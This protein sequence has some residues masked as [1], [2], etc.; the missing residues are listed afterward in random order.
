MQNDGNLV[1]YD[2]Y[3]QPTWASNTYMKGTGP[4]KLVMQN[5]RNLVIYDCYGTAIWASNTYE[6]NLDTL[7]N[8]QVLNQ[9]SVLISKNQNFCARMQE[10]GNFVCYHGM[11]FQSQN[12]F[13]ASNTGGIGLGPFRLV[14]QNDGNL[15]LYDRQGNATWS[16]NTWKQGTGPY[17]LVMQDD[18][19]L[20]LYDRFNQPTWASGTNV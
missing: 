6:T 10:D 9:N 14:C 19:N 17:R 11:N 16:S 13:W 12:A 3:Q 20:V 5:D 1:I 18:R 8:D 2:R 7:E 4:Y 15:V